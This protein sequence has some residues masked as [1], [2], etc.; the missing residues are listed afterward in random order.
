MIYITIYIVN[1]TLH[2]YSH[3]FILYVITGVK[4]YSEHTTHQILETSEKEHDLQSN[5]CDCESTFHLKLILKVVSVAH[6]FPPHSVRKF[7]L[8]VTSASLALSPWT[9]RPKLSV[10]CRQVT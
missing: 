6:T 3:L 2:I 9:E 4:I 10:L 1:W 8:D 7:Q 5:I